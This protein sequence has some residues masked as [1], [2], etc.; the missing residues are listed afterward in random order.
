MWTWV[1]R[2]SYSIK[3]K[4]GLQLLSITSTEHMDK[5]AYL[6]IP[7]LV[8]IIRTGA[9]SLS[10]ARLRK[11]KHSISSMCT[12]STNSTPGTISA[13]PSS[14]HSATLALIC[15]LTSDLI[16]PVSPEQSNVKISYCPWN[17]LYIIMW[18]TATLEALHR[19]MS[20]A[21]EIH[22]Y[23]YKPEKS[24]RKPWVLLFIT[25]ISWRVTVC[26]TSFLFCSS[27]SGHCTNLVYKQRVTE[28]KVI[29]NTSCSYL[30]TYLWSHSVI[31]SSSCEW[32]AKLSNFTCGLVYGDNIST[33]T[34]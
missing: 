6:V 34:D 1:I 32:S 17:V 16:S 14:L 11:E 30:V 12:S 5:G 18:N 33:K 28:S 26:T 25:S 19:F 10:S 23:M 20:I 3:Q 8:A 22:S 4:V 31:V 24:A 7:L 21:V 15:S 29:P 2:S 13:L 9:I 27:P